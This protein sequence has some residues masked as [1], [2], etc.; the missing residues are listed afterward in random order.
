MVMDAESYRPLESG[1]CENETIIEAIYSGLWGVDQ[2]IIEV[3]AYQG[4]NV[5]QSIF[6]TCVWVG[7]FSEAAD[8]THPI[9]TYAV[10]RR[11]V[12]LN[13]CGTIKAGDTNVTR[14]LKARFAP[15]E[16]NHGKGTKEAPGWFYG[17]SSHKWQA[18]AA[19]VTGLDMMERGDQL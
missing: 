12:Q 5:G 4:M 17:F 11:W 2:L 8:R 10:K 14:A 13:L 18:Y 7:R 6:D 9:P 1:W 15:N 19:G 3:I 16:S